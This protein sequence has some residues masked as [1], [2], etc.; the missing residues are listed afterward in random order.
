VRDA[1]PRVVRQQD[2][3]A[4]SSLIDFSETR[5]SCGVIENAPPKCRDIFSMLVPLYGCA[6]RKRSRCSCVSA[7]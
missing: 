4:S 6:S 7:P 2:S 5:T 1:A 3:A